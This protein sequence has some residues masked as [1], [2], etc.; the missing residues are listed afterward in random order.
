MGWLIALGVLT[1]IAILPIGVS[2]LYDEDGKET[3]VVP[4]AVCKINENIEVL[5][6]YEKDNI[7]VKC[8]CIF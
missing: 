7:K 2:A 3:F 4:V 8:K 5:T 6:K 1:L